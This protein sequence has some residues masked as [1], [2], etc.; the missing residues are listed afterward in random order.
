[1]A[2]FQVESTADAGFVR[3]VI[4]LRDGGFAALLSGVG[5]GPSQVTVFG[6]STDGGAVRVG[7]DVNL[8]HDGQLLAERADGGFAVLATVR[9]TSPDNGRS[10]VTLFAASGQTVD[11][12]LLREDILIFSSLAVR[13]LS[14]SP[15]EPNPWVTGFDETG[16]FL[17]RVDPQT[18][19]PL[20][21]PDVLR[22]QAPP[23]IFD[24]GFGV[25]AGFGIRDTLVTA[26]ALTVPDGLVPTF[27]D[28]GF[29]FSDR[30]IA[31][32]GNMIVEVGISRVRASIAEGGTISGSIIV[33][34]SEPDSGT[35]RNVAIEDLG[36]GFVEARVAEVPGLGFAVLIVV[37]GGEIGTSGLIDH[38]EI[39]FYDFSGIERARTEITDLIGQRTSAADGTFSFTTL[40][41]PLQAGLR[42]LT[43]WGPRDAGG[44]RLPSQ[45]TVTELAV[46]PLG[47]DVG[48][49]STGTA[50][51]D[52]LAGL[53][54]T[55]LLFGQAGD[56]TLK[57]FA[58]DDVLEG[59]SGG[60]FLF[61]GEGGDA[62][63]G[64]DGSDGLEG[65]G[66]DDQLLGEG[67]DDAL[68][69][70]AGNDTLLGG[71][72]DDSLFGGKG[73]DSLSGGEGFDQIDGGA[74]NDVLEGGTEA[75]LLQGEDG[76]DTQRGGDGDDA[77]D[78]GA[79]ADSLLGGAEDDQLAGGKGNDR[80]DGG[81]GQDELVGG[82]GNDLLVGGPDRFDG[83]DLLQGNDGDDTLIGGQGF[84]TLTGGSGDDS[85]S[86][87][88]GEDLLLGLRGSDTLIGN[89]GDDMIRGFSRADTLRGGA[90][91]DTLSGDEG[92][93]LLEGGDG[94]D[95]FLFTEVGHMGS[96]TVFDRIRDFDPLEDRLDFAFVGP[97]ERVSSFTA[98]GEAEF[99]YNLTT[100]VLSGDTDGDGS[101][102]FRLTFMSRPDLPD[103][104]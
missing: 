43:V 67:G 79:G 58:G 80:L 39:R 17:E 9:D 37:E 101:A 47:P 60:D 78:G 75:D 77:L 86:G 41:D 100:G 13:N 3:A 15:S 98:A 102:N 88:A 20:D 66:G 11:S 57:G 76:N 81:G 84:D 14:A 49:E 5:G 29:F 92:A 72:G 96:L 31:A 51:G 38:A 56:D 2:T 21:T 53:S 48:I 87:G 23:L 103:L 73:A 71:V 59:D 63:G 42:F 95:T 36:L 69:G 12:F 7:T 45:G 24:G 97:M 55:D 40:V 46:P 1:M 50:Y 68:S 62:L 65:G 32:A 27:A 90:G 99:T 34:L 64:G 28:P 93:D 85:L 52:Y 94:A 44:I 104:L 26:V 89:A 54:N 4:A 82:A 10:H 25:S 33:N 6:A 19:R 61:G 83:A 70:D 91:D 35:I 30:E 16:F 18:L 74:G 22:V 8:V